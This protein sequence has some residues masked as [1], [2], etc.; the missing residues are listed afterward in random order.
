MQ[1]FSK[2]ASATAFVAM[3]AIAPS[4][5]E[6]ELTPDQNDEISAGV[7]AQFKDLGFDVSDIRMV[8]DDNPLSGRAGAKH[9]VLE[10]DIVITEANFEEMKK[11]SVHHTGPVGEQYRTTNLVSSP[12]T[13]RVLG[14]TGGS[15]ALDTK[16]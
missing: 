12:R 1:N 9:Y 15:N 7:K 8:A 6:Q 5:S 14:Y 11:S 4:C 3:F 13:I 2:L 16:M 10:G